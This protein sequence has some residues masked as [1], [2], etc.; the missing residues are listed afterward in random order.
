LT[1][2]TMAPLP[3][4][5]VGYPV[6]PEAVERYRVLKNLP[7]YD[8][9][10]LLQ[11]LESEIGVPLTLARVERDAE[12]GGAAPDYY[13]CSFADYSGRPHD[14]ANLLAIPVPPAFHQLPQLI[15]V[16]GDLQRLFAPR[17]MISSYDQSGKSR[18][19]ELALPIGGGHV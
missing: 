7:Q 8:N 9:R 3:T 1:T 11:D 15:P 6:S 10:L 5:L 16:E 4:S 19:N 2:T 14:S 13:I 17:A 12:D 18:V